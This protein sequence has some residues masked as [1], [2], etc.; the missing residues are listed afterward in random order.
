MDNYIPPATVAPLAARG[1]RTAR[2]LPI[3]RGGVVL[4]VVGQGSGSNQRA[5]SAGSTL[6][7]AAQATPFLRMSVVL[8]DRP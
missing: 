4:A 3:F 2:C 8:P 7:Q 6:M 5:L 1:D